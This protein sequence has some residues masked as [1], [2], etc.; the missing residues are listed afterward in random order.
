MTSFQN[1]I[2][3]NYQNINLFLIASL[4]ITFPFNLKLLFFFRLNDLFGISLI[5]FNINLLS[6]KNWIYIL[7]VFSIFTFSNILSFFY[8]ESIFYIKI[9]FYYKIF[10]IIFLFFILNKI[11]EK[12]DIGFLDKIYLL[13]RYVFNIFILLIIFI[14]FE[15]YFIKTNIFYPKFFFSET[16]DTHILTNIFL[17][18]LVFE[19]ICN[20]QKKFTYKDFFDFNNNYLFVLILLLLI[21]KTFSSSVYYYLFF[22]LFYAFNI[23]LLNDKF[24]SGK[25]NISESYF[26][27]YFFISLFIILVF[28]LL[29]LK[30]YFIDE[31]II[32]ELNFVLDYLYFG[33]Q[34]DFGWFDVRISGWVTYF[35]DLT[36]LNLLFGFGFINYEQIFH[37]SFFIFL[38]SSIGL[39]G[40]ILLFYCTYKIIYK[41]IFNDL[42]FIIF[43]ICIIGANLFI[44]EFILI[45]RYSF[46]V[47]L[48]VSIYYIKFHK[49]SYN[50]S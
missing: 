23:I 24:I 30:I 25:I 32:H 28:S 47:V 3:N 44:T 29:F 17:T 45:S 20:Y 38:F 40:I 37:D 34:L 26:N 18:F 9:A 5:L 1:L 46:M 2:K 33:N 21:L 14:Q 12:L 50:K 7:S 16:N 4:I 39:F 49:F 15:N 22:L 41:P 36:I 19:I 35:N 42:N 13:N 43:L 31:L 48:M 11:F 10:V 27:F 6:K 8:A